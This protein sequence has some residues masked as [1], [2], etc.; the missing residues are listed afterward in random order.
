MDNRQRLVFARDSHQYEYFVRKNKRK[1]SLFKFVNNHNDLRGVNIEDYKIITLSG[2][3]RHR[4]FERINQEFK[5]RTRGTSIREYMRANPERNLVTHPR[6]ESIRFQNGGIVEPRLGVGGV[7]FDE[8]PTIGISD[9][10]YS[11]PVTTN[12]EGWSINEPGSYQ[13]SGTVSA[14]ERITIPEGVYIGTP[15]TSGIVEYTGDVPTLE[16]YRNTLTQAVQDSAVYG[17][18]YVQTA[19][20]EANN[21]TMNTVSL[22]ERD[23]QIALT[24]ER[25]RHEEMM[26]AEL[27]NDNTEEEESPGLMERIRGIF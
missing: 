3:N 16:G 2:F 1:R 8:S 12:D 22:Y 11:V 19:M 21:L 7:V 9:P 5:F 17:Q 24:R 26:R 13:F 20:N 6:R 10:I 23:R 27:R 14:G 15:P 18:S 25:E 4:Y